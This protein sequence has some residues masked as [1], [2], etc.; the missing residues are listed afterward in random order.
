MAYCPPRLLDDI[1]DLFAEVRTWAGVIEKS[2]GVKEGGSS[3][4]RGPSP[5]RGDK[6]SCASCEC[7][8]G[9]SSGDRPGRFR[10]IDQ[11]S[12][13]RGN[14]DEPAGVAHGSASDVRRVRYGSCRRGG[15]LR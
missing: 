4:S 2:P 15:G 5:P 14:A 9:R 12:T 11:A 1:G 10:S 7:T 6:H 8:M 3:T 13:T